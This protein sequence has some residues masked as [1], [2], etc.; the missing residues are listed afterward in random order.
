MSTAIV[1]YSFE[2]ILGEKQMAAEELREVVIANNEI[3]H[4]QKTKPRGKN[5]TIRQETHKQIW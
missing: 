2:P 3:T 5:G 1:R 4:E